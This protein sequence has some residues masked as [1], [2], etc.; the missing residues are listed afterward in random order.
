M[1]AVRLAVVASAQ[2]MQ[3]LTGYER[4]PEFVPNLSHSQRVPRP[5][6]GKDPGVVRLLQRG[7]SQV[8]QNSCG[9]CVAAVRCVR[10]FVPIA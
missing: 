3:V 5:S 1:R 8:C 9:C 4:L 10:M 7:C 6:S 2:V